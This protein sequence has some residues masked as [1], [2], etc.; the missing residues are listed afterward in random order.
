MVMNNLYNSNN[1][2]NNY[3]N[4]K[5]NYNQNIESNNYS[6][7]D[8][9]NSVKEDTRL[10][11]NR[12]YI[13]TSYDKDDVYG[14]YDVA[15]N[16]SKTKV[17]VVM[18][19]MAAIIVGVLG[20]TIINSITRESNE[21]SAKE[22]QIDIVE[23]GSNPILGGQDSEVQFN[24]EQ[25]EDTGDYVE[26]EGDNIET[27]EGGSL[28]KTDESSKEV[29]PT[30]TA[31]PTPKPTV[32]PAIEI[33]KVKEKVRNLSLSDSRVV[34]I[35]NNFSRYPLNLM[36]DIV[37][38]NEMIDYTVGYLDGITRSYDE[39]ID[40]SANMSDT[41]Y[42]IPLLIQWDTRWG[43]YKYGKSTIGISGCGPTA[44]NMVYIAL[45]GDATM[46][47]LKMAKFSTDYGYCVPGVGTSWSLMTE[48]AAKLGIYSTRL[49]KSEENMKNSLE[50]GKFI[51][52]SMGPGI[53]T[54]KGHFIVFS[55]YENGKFRINDPFC[56]EHS[57]KSWDYIEFASQVKALWVLSN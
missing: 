38:N 49:S 50:Q 56:M 15:D 31:T 6:E 48:G 13:D 32:D 18:A 42:K 40:I 54:E 47:P 34:D 16:G 26:G 41:T 39:N 25:I 52:A 9:R 44:L 28:E 36:K 29:V 27:D 46:N 7:L 12:K 22:G 5:N 53:F 45:K 4:Y 17:I 8:I 14:S 24:E 37:R 19:I 1:E 3:D 10:D 33:N 35:Y 21:S 43:Y 30:A 20:M 11:Y 2:S 57:R 23:V 55:G 51:I